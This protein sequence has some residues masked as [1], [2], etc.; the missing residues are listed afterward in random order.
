MPNH[1]T[2]TSWKELYDC[3]RKDEEQELELF[4]SQECSD[5]FF[6]DACSKNFH[7]TCFELSKQ[8]ITKRESECFKEEF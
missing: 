2:F 8:K 3:L 1:S 6:A 4:R 7:R 5:S